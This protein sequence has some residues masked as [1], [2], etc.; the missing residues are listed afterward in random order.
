M[1]SVFFNVGFLVRFIMAVIGTVGFALIFNTRPRYLPM[2]GI[3][4]GITYAIYYFF[5]VRVFVSVFAA[6]FLS[7]IFLALYS[8]VYARIKRAPAIIF[9]IPCTVPIV[10]GSSLYYTMANL[11]SRDFDAALYH[12]GNT[13]LI[14]IGIAGGILA[15]SISVNVYTGISARIKANRK[16]KF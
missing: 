5:E 15:V 7:S 14:G 6:A 10:P 12:L 2:L 1:L 11:I 13:A 9:M 16:V 3:G 4:G 8:E